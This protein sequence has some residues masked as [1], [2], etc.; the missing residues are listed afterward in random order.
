M[1][2]TIA[3]Q[4]KSEGLGALAQSADDVYEA[5]RKARQM[6]D[7][8]LVNISIEDNAGHKIDGDDLLACVKGE[9]SLSAD[10]KT[11]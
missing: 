5:L 2:Y 6:R 9:K 11:N 7:T 1:A 3:G 4:T 8:G 10:L